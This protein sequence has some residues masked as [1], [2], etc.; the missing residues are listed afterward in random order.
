M[1]VAMEDK[2]ML[3][4]MHHKAVPIDVTA[5]Y[6]SKADRTTLEMRRILRDLV[7]EVGS[8]RL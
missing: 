6:H 4:R 7:A 2:A 8:E 3:E 1:L 5:E